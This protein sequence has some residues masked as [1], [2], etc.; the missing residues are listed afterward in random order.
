MTQKAVGHMIAVA[1]ESLGSI[2]T[3]ETWSRRQNN[4]NTL[5]V[6][7]LVHAFNAEP[8]ETKRFSQR[9]D[10]ILALAKKEAYASGESRG[11]RR[12]GSTD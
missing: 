7:T 1:E 10:K 11:G 9:V 8:V 12:C 6:G 2:K 4:H 3:G 5:T